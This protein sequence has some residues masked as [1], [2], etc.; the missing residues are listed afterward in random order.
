MSGFGVSGGVSHADHAQYI[1]LTLVNF[2]SGQITL[3][4]TSANASNTSGT[5]KVSSGGTAVADITLV[6]AYA[7]SNFHVSS[8]AGGTVEITDPSVAE[9]PSGNIAGGNVL[10]VNTPDLDKVT[11]GGS[12]GTFQPDQSGTFT[13]TVADLAAQNGIDLP[14]N[15]FDASTTLVSEHNSTGG[16]LTLPA[17]T[18]TAAMA[19][20]VN[21]MASTLVAGAEGHE[22]TLVTESLKPEQ[23]PLLAN[24]H[25]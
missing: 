9:Q 7:T 15:G 2:A 14:G 21:Y 8:A 6:G 24:P 25:A 16:A 11:S 10:E 19:L 18:Y 1:D 17:D 4:Y 12:G 3:S 20:L 5:L 22:S 13:G 23:P